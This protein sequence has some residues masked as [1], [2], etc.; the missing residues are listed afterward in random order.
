MEDWHLI[1]IG[2]QKT[3]HHLFKDFDYFSPELQ[4]E[5]YPEL[6]KALGWNNI[7]RRN[8]GYV[9]AFNQGADIIATV[10]D[11]NIPYDGWGKTYLN[12]EIVA[13]YYESINEVFDPLSVTN[14]PQLWHRGY[15]VELLKTKNLVNY[16]GKK[17]ITLY[18]G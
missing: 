8:I 5:L 15:P 4:D 3:P 10:D 9:E 6:S 11:D 13:D 2:D 12:E 14:Y 16:K 17:K 1:V 7:Q 18:T